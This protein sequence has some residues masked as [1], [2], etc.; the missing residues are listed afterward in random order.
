[1]VS[2]SVGVMA[3]QVKNKLLSI[4]ISVPQ[5][6]LSVML[7]QFPVRHSTACGY[8]TI[9]SCYNQGLDYCLPRY[10]IILSELSQVSIT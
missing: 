3:G 10:N 7:S 9:N 2:V 8:W 1:M 5:G 6:T 4:W